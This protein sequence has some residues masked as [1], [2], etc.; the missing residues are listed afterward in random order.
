MAD[1]VAVE[2]LFTLVDVRVVVGDRRHKVVSGLL[3]QGHQDQLV[4]VHDLEVLQLVDLAG[5]EERDG[6][7]VL[8]LLIDSHSLEMVRVDADGVQ[9]LILLRDRLFGRVIAVQVLKVG[10]AVQHIAAHQTDAEQNS[11]DHR[12]D[13]LFIPEYIRQERGHQAEH[14]HVDDRVQHIHVPVHLHGRCDADQQQVQ[15]DRDTEHDVIAPGNGQSAF[16]L[17][18]EKVDDERHQHNTDTKGQQAAEHLVIDELQEQMEVVKVSG[19][20]LQVGDRLFSPVFRECHLDHTRENGQRHQ[21]CRSLCAE[22]DQSRFPLPV[23]EQIDHHS[24]RQ[25]DDVDDAI[26]LRQCG[27]DADTEEP[28]QMVPERMV[29]NVFR[30]G[31]AHD[32]IN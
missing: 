27:K 4:V 8:R 16:G 3:P 17:P 13:L 5:L 1:F 26:E 22:D 21:T 11:D 6:L 10:R 24:Q 18:V 31:I 19:R 32:L 29:G 9:V 14:H 28:E 2:E 12:H 30:R 20:L 15:R 23:K 7:V 25:S